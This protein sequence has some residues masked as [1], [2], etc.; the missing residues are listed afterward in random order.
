MNGDHRL[1]FLTVTLDLSVWKAMRVLVTKSLTVTV[2]FHVWCQTQDGRFRPVTG[3]DL[4]GR[5]R[6]NLNDLKMS[7]LA[8][9]AGDFDGDGRADFVQLGRGKE[10]SI[11][12]GRPDCS[13]PS[14]PDATLQLRSEP[15]DVALVQVRD[16]DG[17]GR[18]DLMI[19]EPR[20]AAE[21][22]LAPPVRLDLYLSGGRP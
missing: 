22:G 7:Q 10:V 6:F 21:P 15:K 20:P 16:L 13:F 17:D 3:L 4:A 14:R 19:V 2:D 12:L 9:F 1:D 5:F 8:F 18:A 11:H